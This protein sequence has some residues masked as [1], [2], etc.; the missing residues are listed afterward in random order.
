[1]VQSIFGVQSR[2]GTYPSSGWG[3]VCLP[4]GVVEVTGHEDKLIMRTNIIY[5]YDRK[6][7]AGCV[8]MVKFGSSND[9]GNYDHNGIDFFVH[10]M[11]ISPSKAEK[12][13]VL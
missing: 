5:T 6:I 13:V 1:M 4:D 10:H 3:G 12:W 7:N 9:E 8:G 11:Q 2:C